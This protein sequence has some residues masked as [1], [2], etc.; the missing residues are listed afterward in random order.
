MTTVA[1]DAT[2][3]RA[4]FL[5]AVADLLER[6]AQRVPAGPYS[7]PAYSAG[8]PHSDLINLGPQAHIEDPQARIFGRDAPAIAEHITAI[9]DPGFA[10]TLVALWRGIAGRHRAGWTN[11]KWVEGDIVQ[12]PQC[13]A[14]CG[15]WPCPDLLAAV[16]AAQAYL[17]GTTT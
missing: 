15:N 3:D 5:M 2:A 17:T 6:R 12:V 9:A 7:T 1:P 11:P 4:R 16:A 10:L 13:A 14:R 8:T